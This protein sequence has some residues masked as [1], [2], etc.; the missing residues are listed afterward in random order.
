MVALALG[1]ADGVRVE[2]DAYDLHTK[3]GIKAEVKS[4]A[5]VQSWQQPRPSTI[6]FAIRPT[7]GW[8]AETNTYSTELKRQADVYVF[9]LLAYYDKATL[10]PLNIAQWQFYILST[11]ILNAQV[12]T[13]KTISLT[14]YND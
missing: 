12:P 6:T 14:T 5:Y 9:A 2:W 3:F 4:A 13:Q 7:L 8:E 11:A 10:D 1:V